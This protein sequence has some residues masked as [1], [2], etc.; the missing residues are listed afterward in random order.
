MSEEPYRAGERRPI[1]SRERKSSLAIA[2][3]LV[4]RG[5][6][7]NTI[8]L[9]GM[10]CGIAAGILFAVTSMA[11]GLRRP[12]WVAGAI[13]VQLRLLANMFDGM[14]AIAS[15]KASPAGELY[16]EV[17][18]RVSDAAIFIGLGYSFGGDAILGYAATGVAIF[19]AYIRAVGKV[20]GAR[21]EFCG[22]MAKQHRMFVATVLGLYAGLAP[23]GW[24]PLWNGPAGNWGMAAM[25]LAVII[26]GG[27]FTAWR[28]LWR[29]AKM[30]RKPQP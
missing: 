7:P 9:A 19:T 30:L 11:P 20:A 22:P 14:V 15:K 27:L 28:R 21:Q 5:I 23:S 26:V 10:F 12:A 24:Q 6:S 17:P 8:S 25:A 16:N 4:H 18:D 13:F 29:T 1:A 3:W 2:H